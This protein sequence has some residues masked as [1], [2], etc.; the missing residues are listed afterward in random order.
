MIRHL[1]RVFTRGFFVFI[2]GAIVSLSAAAQTGNVT[3]DYDDLGR[4]KT[5][6]YEDTEARYNYTYDAAGNRT[7]HT[8]D[9]GLVNEVRL[10]NKTV[11]EGDALCYTVWRVG[12]SNVE[13][14]VRVETYLPAS[15]ADYPL[16]FEGS[17]GTY[18]AATSGVDYLPLAENLWLTIPPSSTGAPTEFCIT[19]IE[20]EDPEPEEHVFARIAEVVNGIVDPLQ[21]TAFGRIKNDDGPVVAFH[22]SNTMKAEPEGYGQKMV[23]DVF[24]TGVAQVPHSVTVEFTDGTAKYGLDY[25]GAKSC[26]LGF[27]VEDELL[28]CE[29]T[30]LPDEIYEG[31]ETVMA[32]ITSVSGGAIISETPEGELL[33][34]Q[35][36]ATGMISDAGDFPQVKIAQYG[37]KEGGVLLHTIW[38]SKD[39]TQPI[40]VNYQLC[41]TDN[42][43]TNAECKAAKLKGV[44]ASLND[45]VPGTAM[46]G[47]VVLPATLNADGSPSSAEPGGE[48]T[49]YSQSDTTEEG[50]EDY[51]VVLTSISGGA[52]AVEDGRWLAYGHIR[53]DDSA[54]S[55]FNIWGGKTTAGQ[56]LV[57]TVRRWGNTTGEVR[58]TFAPT[59]NKSQVKT[60]TGTVINRK[61]TLAVEGTDYTLPASNEVVFANGQTEQTFSIPTIPITD[62]AMQGG[63]FLPIR[64]SMQTGYTGSF[65]VK[66]RVGTITDDRT[67]A[68]TLAQTVSA[69]EAE[70]EIVFTGAMDYPESVP[71][72]IP[73][74]TVSGGTADEDADYVSETGVI[75]VPAGTTTFA[76]PITII[77]DTD[78]DGAEADETLVLNVIPE[79]VTGSPDPV[80]AT[81]TILN[82]LDDGCNATLKVAKKTFGVDEFE[83]GTPIDFRQQ[84]GFCTTSAAFGGGVTS[85]ATA[86][87]AMQS[88]LDT[89]MHDYQIDL[90]ANS[91]EE[92]EDFV[93]KSVLL[94]IPGTQQT[95]TIP[96]EIIDDLLNEST[97][98]LA[99]RVTP[100]SGADV[101]GSGELMIM[102]D[103]PGPLY[104]VS[105]VTAGEN[106]LLVFTVSKAGQ[107][108]LTSSVI[109]ETVDGTAIAGEDYSPASGIL[110]FAPTETEKTVVVNGAEDTAF[111]LTETFYV[112]LSQPSVGSA[113]EKARG[114]ATISD[115]DAVPAFSVSDAAAIEGDELTFAVSLSQP[116]SL[117]H[118]VRAYTFGGGAEDGADYQAISADLTFAPGETLQYVT[119]ATSDDDTI[120]PDE[121]FELKI[122]DPTNGATLGDMAGNGTIENDDVLPPVCH[123]KWDVNNK[124][125]EWTVD[126]SGLVATYANNSA[127]ES[128]IM[129]DVSLTTGKWYWEITSSASSSSREWGGV[130]PTN[131]TTAV[132]SFHNQVDVWF[133][134]HGTV[135]A[136]F[137]KGTGSANASTLLNWGAATNTSVYSFALDL[138]GKTIKVRRDGGAGVTFNINSAVTDWSP[139]IGSRKDTSQSITANFGASAFGY[140]VPAGFTAVDEAAICAPQP[141]SNIIDG[142][143]YDGTASFDG[144][145]SSTD[146]FKVG[147]GATVQISMAGGAGGD[148]AEDNR[149]GGEGGAG[150]LSFTATQEF[151]LRARVGKKGASDANSQTLQIDVSGG[152]AAGPSG[153]DSGQG[154]GATSVSISPNGV[155]WTAVAVVGAG[156]GAS[157]YGWGGDGGG[158]NVNGVDATSSYPNLPQR[159]GKGATTTSVGLSGND[160]GDGGLPGS[161]GEV[162]TTTV[163]GVAGQGNADFAIG[164]GGGAS[165]TGSSSDN[166]GG[167]GAGYYGGGGGRN[168]SG[169]G[170]GGSGYFDAAA[171]TAIAGGTPT[172]IS[173]T[174]GGNAGDGYVS[175]TVAGTPAPSQA[176]AST[177]PVFFISDVT[178]AEGDKFVFTVT[179]SEAITEAVDLSYSMLDGTALAAGDYTAATGTLSF[180]PGD[181]VKTITIDT[182]EDAIAEDNEDFSIQLVLVSGTATLAKDTGTGTI[183][184][185]DEAPAFSVSTATANV[186]EGQPAFI[187]VALNRMTENE[188]SIDYTTVDG[189]AL[190]GADYVATSGTL[191]FSGGEMV[192]QI[193]V[194]TIDDTLLSGGTFSVNISAPTGGANVVGDTA[195]VTLVA[196]APTGGPADV[197]L[198]EQK[199]YP[200]STTSATFDFNAALGG[201]TVGFTGHATYN[202]STSW[203][204]HQLHNA[205]RSNNDWA[206]LSGDTSQKFGEWTFPQAVLVDKIFIVP[207]N[208]NDQFPTSVTVIVD[209][210][211]QIV[212]TSS[213]GISQADGLVTAYSGFGYYIQPD[214]VGTVWRLEFPTA[215][216]YIGEIEFHGG[217]PAVE[218]VATPDPVIISVANASVTE[219]GLLYFTFTATGYSDKEVAVSYDIVSGTATS[220]ADYTAASGTLYFAPGETEQTIAIQTSADTAL[221]ADETF[222]LQ[223]GIVQGDGELAAPTAVGTIVNVGGELPPVF[224]VSAT[225]TSLD[226]GG[227]VTVTVS[228]SAATT[229]EY[230]VTLAT[231]DGTAIAGTHY[232]ALSQALTFAPTELS[233]SFTI[234]TVDDAIS[235][236]ERAFTVNL[237]APTGGASIGIAS[238]PVAITDNDA[239][240][241]IETF[242]AG[243]TWIAPA[244][245]IEL[246]VLKGKGGSGSPA[247]TNSA[248][249]RVLYID[250]SS[251]LSAQTLSDAYAHADAQAASILSQ[252]STTSY[253]SASFTLREYYGTQYVFNNGR[254]VS[255]VKKG[256]GAG[257]NSSKTHVTGLTKYTA[258][259][260]GSSAS[261]YGYTFPGGAGGA[262]AEVIYNNVAVVAGQSYVLTVPSGGSITIEYWAN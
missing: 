69:S 123:A 14:Q 32:T 9:G 215:K 141:A 137:R 193:T 92:G 225:P 128:G 2:F 255:S 33:Q 195:I 155:N 88:G 82:D 191:T 217:F 114:T 72:D 79:V 49:V 247:S 171:I 150:V 113:L 139:I 224:S 199:T 220:G 261:G 54:E 74:T 142:Q 5:V 172:L 64:I 187:T 239:V 11:N 253:G 165:S 162:G 21:E 182:V 185:D 24:K 104:S 198:I 237:S 56:P 84:G 126:G 216:T 175:V 13:T 161:D 38:H 131:T 173:A 201:G 34:G 46:N 149:F 63:K 200:A 214:L 41:V 196:P 70:E 143:I 29:V 151:F 244:G 12:S 248:S 86:A 53:N 163:N 111:E 186:V 229:Y 76:I 210:V 99:I 206:D 180:A 51:A 67:Q 87:M 42:L 120:E 258:G 20:D 256:A 129:A 140:S 246:A 124:G 106:N 119:I 101:S 252:L 262:A 93:A 83:R 16:D 102:D 219:G 30:L 80:Q 122:T 167:G 211:S 36:I 97:E 188:Y 121:T 44:T 94:S 241:Y 226:E 249:A 27:G 10:W 202:N 230:G 181:A 125:G 109:Y 22:V 58:L 66:E 116:S 260:T 159:L 231:T 259:T 242:T 117:T 212:A 28:K 179:A 90:V 23:F 168:N 208:Q 228:K 115:N 157:K 144:A 156:G 213:A 61:S 78:L 250:D 204:P 3:Y 227:S 77:N 17:V 207:R 59:G 218:E 221:E 174:Q 238:A 132:D 184:D 7:V 235:Q 75:T 170:G 164:G 47:S 81:G 152:G 222:D 65:A 232:T 166:G 154:G 100:L 240:Y 148:N 60:P 1:A 31:G 25:E 147:A 18:N 52:R 50:N 158:L 6:T 153:N 110:T 189:T 254:S 176:P 85:M 135:D 177:G 108:D 4:L 145:T 178:L 68:V 89:S 55:I 39:T 112:D 183:L 138:E 45:L 15:A 223:L 127:I 118:S 136:S 96:M 234:P 245:I 103:D 243:Q 134:N 203:G 146:V 35:G 160:A 133:G 205:A 251:V 73:Y 236:G 130:A 107:T 190:T 62:P 257:L 98:D 95:A 209:G 40:T 48:I 26:E 43:T 19:T 57:Y 71:V 91:A 105:D 194:D 8:V 233:K 197:L 37:S 192:K 169:A